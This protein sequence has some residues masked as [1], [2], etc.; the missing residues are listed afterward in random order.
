MTEK[1][2][3]AALAGKPSSVVSFSEWIR[4][5]S[6][7]V[8]A[9]RRGFGN[10][11]ACMARLAAWRF[12]SARV[13]PPLWKSRKGTMLLTPHYTW[14]AALE[15]FGYD[16]YRLHSLPQSCSLRFFL[17]I[18]AHIGSFSLAVTERWP[19]AAGIACEPSSSNFAALRH[20]LSLNPGRSVECIKAAVVGDGRP[21]SLQFSYDPHRPQSGA[22]LSAPT[23]NGGAEIEVVSA[24]AF[25]ELVRKSPD[26]IDLLK[27]DVEGAEYGI[28]AGTPL[29]LLGRAKRIVLEYHPMPGC[30]ERDIVTRLA[31]A[32][33]EL[34]RH[35]PRL[36]WFGA[37]PE[38]QRTA[39]SC[40]AEK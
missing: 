21:S 11:I 15:C 38:S 20:N 7:A 12:I 27:I 39:T 17:D 22:L 4:I 23:A 16:S 2:S 37:W 25:S 8:L 28:I 13:R 10:G 3:P 31:Q 35:E 32:G 24:L 40:R 14:F 1:P 18:G 19:N 9:A 30:S 36:M 6:G 26:T 34:A 29:D 33:L 5:R